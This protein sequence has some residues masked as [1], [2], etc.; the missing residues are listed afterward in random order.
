MSVCTSIQQ[1]VYCLAIKICAASTQTGDSAT[2]AAYL[3][4]ELQALL[5]DPDFNN[6][7]DWQI[8]WGPAVWQAPFSTFSDQA[9][10]VCYNS[11]Q[12]Y[13]VVP[14][15]ATN[16]NAPYN[17]FFEDLGAV[18]HYMVPV[19]GGNA[20][21]VSVGNFAGLQALLS[22]QVSGT[23]L[24]DFLSTTASASD[25]LVFCGHSLGG[26]LTPLLAYTL[27]PKGSAGSGW[28]N[29]YTFP[30]AGPTTADGSFASA[31]AAAYPVVSGSG[32]QMWNANQYNVHDLVPNAW[33]GASTGPGLAQ[34][35]GSAWP[36]TTVMY[37]SS[38]EMAAEIAALR[39]IA[40][41]FAGGSANPY[42]AA[43]PNPLFT[44]AR[45]YGEIEDSA[46]LEK[47]ILFQHTTA[48]NQEFG[49][50]ALFDDAQVQAWIQPPLLPLVRGVRGVGA[51]VA[52]ARTAAVVEAAAAEPGA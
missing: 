50:T 34:I 22:L 40:E 11:S 19:P 25:T 49:V 30:T 9:A 39:N 6:G 13:Y 10:A 3:Q 21:N 2:L 29:V 31:F 46:T 23:G 7:D 44:G 14:V 48:Y 38:V 47:E 20:G 51:V 8:A 37:Y 18:P 26:G 41:V 42:V 5:S 16:P 32:Y 24:Q 15:S 36:W 43:N 52:A 4:T 35:S 17:V 45:Q 27:Y 28:A 33:A 1:Q 12:N